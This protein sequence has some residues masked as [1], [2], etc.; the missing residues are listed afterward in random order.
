[1]YKIKKIG[2]VFTSKCVGTGLPSYKKRIYRAAVSQRLR[3]TAL[4][5][6]TPLPVEQK[7]VGNQSQ[8]GCCREGKCH[9]LLLG[10]ETLLPCQY[11][12]RG[13]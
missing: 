5:K 2:K 11:F 1:M 9:L 6:E 10:I 4:E 7:A 12:D 8:T 13:V 3:N